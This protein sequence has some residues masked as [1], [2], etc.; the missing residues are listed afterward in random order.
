MIKQG[1]VADCAGPLEHTE[2]CIVG[3]QRRFTTQVGLVFQDRAQR[4]QAGFEGGQLGITIG[5][6]L[7]QSHAKTLFPALPEIGFVVRVQVFVNIEQHKTNHVP[8]DRVA[9]G[10]MELA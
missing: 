10:S 3:I 2:N 5:H 9:V 8:G 7:L 6:H 4:L 1:V